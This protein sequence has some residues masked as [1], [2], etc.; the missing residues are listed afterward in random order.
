MSSKMGSGLRVQRPQNP[1]MQ[2]TPEMMQNAKQKIC[3]CGS[4]FFQQGISVFTISALVSPIGQELTVNVPVL[5]C[6]N[7]KKAM[8][9]T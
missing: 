1:P 5:I 7:C 9:T 8:V 4:P 3:E 6:M 2:I